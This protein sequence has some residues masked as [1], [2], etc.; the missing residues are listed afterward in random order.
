MKIGEQSVLES[1]LESGLLGERPAR[2]LCLSLPPKQSKAKQAYRRRCRCCGRLLLQKRGKRQHRGD[3]L[4][5][6]SAAVGGRS[7]CFKASSRLWLE[8]CSAAGSLRITE[9]SSKAAPRQGG[10]ARPGL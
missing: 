10:R 3:G 6:D 1:F 2:R 9:L 5:R 8:V 4:V 7:G